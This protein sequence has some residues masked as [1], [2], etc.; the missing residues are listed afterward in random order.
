MLLRLAPRPATADARPATGQGKPVE[1]PPA[2]LDTYAGDY[3]IGPGDYVTIKRDGDRLTAQGTGSGRVTLTPESQ[4]SFLLPR[5]GASLAFVKGD[6]A[7][8]S[9]AVRV[10]LN[11]KERVARRIPTA[12][13]SDFIGDY[14]SRELAV[15][16]EVT[17]RD[18]KLYL[19]HPRGEIEM[20]RTVPDTFEVPFPLKTIGFERDHANRCARLVIDAERVR[21][22]HFG[23]VDLGA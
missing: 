12:P 13:L 14:Y 5:K 23:R 1:I 6:G 19:G 8:Q 22:V 3:E 10:I 21:Q 4:T 16:Y 9:E 11:G 17:S 7:A 18:G 2:L 15:V 20:S